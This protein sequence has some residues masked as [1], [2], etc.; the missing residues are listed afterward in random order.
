MDRDELLNRLR[1][2]REVEGVIE[3]LFRK[4][5]A[6]V[7]RLVL[8][9][10]APFDDCEDLVQ[11]VFLAILKWRESLPDASRYWA[12][13]GTI[14]RNAVKR[15]SSRSERRSSAETVAYR[16]PTIEGFRGFPEP[17]PFRRQLAA[18]E[19]QELSK[20]LRGLTDKQRRCVQ[21][22]YLKG[23]SLEE[24]ATLLG[25]RKGTVGFHLHQ[26]RKSLKTDG[27]HTEV[28]E[29]EAEAGGER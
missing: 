29:P 13:V 2:D 3:V 24:V 15:A 8:R 10:G 25:I 4:D 19:R 14:A 12:Y 28:S 6:V 27:G 17:S 5:Y 1:H 7:R 22:H 21:L 16:D 11:D 26:A 18:L 9:A 23:R 20:A